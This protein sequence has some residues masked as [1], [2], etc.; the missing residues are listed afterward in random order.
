MARYRP[1]RAADLILQSDCDESLLGDENCSD[2]TP[3]KKSASHQHVCVRE[4]PLA[5]K[6]LISPKTAFNRV[7]AISTF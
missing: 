5:L 2:S 3:T 1:D 6:M 4:V 7:S